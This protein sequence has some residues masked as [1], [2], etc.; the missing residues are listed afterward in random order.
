MIQLQLADDVAQGGGGEVFNG[1]QG[2]LH[3]VGVQLGVGDLEE[4]HGVNL[5]GDVVAGDHRLGLEVHHLLFQAHLFYYA[6]D[7][8]NLPVEAGVPGFVIDSQPLHHIRRGLGYDG[9]VGDDDHQGDDE[10]AQQDITEHKRYLLKL[11][12]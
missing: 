10:D 5:H 9:D 11:A 7:E 8:G 3:A 2:T 1:G 6:V 4:D 12:L